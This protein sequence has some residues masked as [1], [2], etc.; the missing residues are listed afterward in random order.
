MCARARP[1]RCYRRRTG[2]RPTSSRGGWLVEEEVVGSQEEG[3]MAWFLGL[4]V[5]AAFSCSLWEEGWACSVLW[6]PLGE[7]SDVDLVE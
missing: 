4:V 2:M 1:R 3:A 6:R 7:Y 5:G